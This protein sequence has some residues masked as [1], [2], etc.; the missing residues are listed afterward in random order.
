MALKTTCYYLEQWYYLELGFVCSII[1]YQTQ[2]CYRRNFR[3]VLQMEFSLFITDITSNGSSTNV[4][5][6]HC[7]S[8][9]RVCFY[10]G[11]LQAGAVVETQH[12]NIADQEQGFVFITD[13]YKQPQQLK[14]SIRTFF[15]HI[16]IQAYRVGVILT[17][18]TKTNSSS[19]PEAA[20]LAEAA[21]SRKIMYAPRKPQTKHAMQKMPVFG[22]G[23]HL[24]S[25]ASYFS[26]DPWVSCSKP[27]HPEPRNACRPLCAP[28][29]Q[30]GPPY[31]G[32]CRTRSA[33]YGASEQLLGISN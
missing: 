28:V 2:T 14:S 12:S 4:A 17:G 7:R 5:F 23:S 29:Q 18:I 33:R 31:P 10:R 6:E 30:S 19:H 21:A 24:S 9:A 20:R 11:Y 3:L 13:I 26:V 1:W 16:L 8:G 25:S 27:W 15:C 32:T 22:S